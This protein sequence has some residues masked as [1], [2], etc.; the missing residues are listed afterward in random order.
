MT[1]ER[2]EA[3]DYRPVTVAVVWLGD[4]ELV[5]QLQTALGLTT[6]RPTSMVDKRTKTPVLAINDIVD[7]R[8]WL[9]ERS[10]DPLS[11]ALAIHLHQ[12]DSPPDTIGPRYQLRISAATGGNHQPTGF[13]IFGATLADLTPEERWETGGDH[14]WLWP[15][16]IKAL[17]NPSMP[18]GLVKL[19]IDY[20]LGNSEVE[21]TD[22]RAEL[23]GFLTTAV[24]RAIPGLAE[25]ISLNKRLWLKTQSRIFLEKVYQELTPKQTAQLLYDYLFK[26]IEGGKPVSAAVLS[27]I[28][29]YSEY[30]GDRL[31][32][33]RITALGVIPKSSDD[34]RLYPKWVVAKSDRGL[35]V[36]TINPRFKEYG[37]KASTCVQRSGGR[38]IDFRSADG[39]LKDNPVCPEGLV[40]WQEYVAGEPQ[41]AEAQKAKKEKDPLVVCYW[42]EGELQ[43]VFQIHNIEELYR[44]LVRQHY[45]FLEIL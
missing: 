14:H 40:G 42:D 45:G 13:S 33:V 12:T 2:G 43:A 29:A 35:Y 20:C 37:Y 17:N 22:D 26:G 5:S 19:E 36:W 34:G 21:N 6:S 41:K 18:P 11:T 10:G 7:E 15:E 3:A 4:Q 9:K 23:A 8:K 24:N 39:R 31:K 28:T 32:M 38:W 44:K 1:P 16:S 27:G 25:A 30:M